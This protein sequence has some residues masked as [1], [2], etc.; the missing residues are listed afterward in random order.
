M[1][2]VSNNYK[3][4]FV[5]VQAVL[6][7]LDIDDYKKIPIDIINA[8]EENKEKNYKYD[9]DESL[10]YSSWNLM[11]ETKAILYNLYKNYLATEEQ[12]KILIEK[13]QN[14]IYKI[15]EEKKKKY[16]TEIFNNKKETDINKKLIKNNEESILKRFINKILKFFRK[17]TK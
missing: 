13:E 3:K 14:E 1:E 6:N 2:M 5:E 15:E 11:A 10:E 17:K 7:C 9:Y 4:A 12:K 8:L 16:S